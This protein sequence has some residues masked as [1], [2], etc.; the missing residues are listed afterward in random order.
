[1]PFVPVPNILEV[2]IEHSFHDKQGIGWVLHYES[3]GPVWTEGSVNELFA[4]LQA[5][6]NTWMKPLVT[7]DVTLNRIRGRVLTTAT[8]GIGERIISPAITGTRSGA[9]MPANVAFS[10]KK[11][12]GLAG[13]SNRGRIYQFGFNEADVT[14]NFIQGAVANAFVAAWTE[15]LLFVGDPDTYGMVVA[16][17]FAGNA[18]RPVGVATDV[19]SISYSDTRIDTRRDRL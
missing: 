6:W 4:Q 9:A 14:G 2:F 10:L 16:S 8:S 11:N 17:K 3:T 5:W 19:I 15:A 12:T 1:M 13:R 7:A 18:P